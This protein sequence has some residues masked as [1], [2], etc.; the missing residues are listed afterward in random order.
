MSTF[1]GMQE[2]WLHHHNREEENPVWG[3]G[4]EWRP[5][6]WE[7]LGG[8]LCQDG[9]IWGRRPQ[10]KGLEGGTSQEGSNVLGTG[11]QF[12]NISLKVTLGWFTCVPACVSIWCLSLDF[13][14]A[15]A[16]DG[17][18]SW[19]YTEYLFKPTTNIWNEYFPNYLMSTRL[20]LSIPH[21]IR[22]H[23]PKVSS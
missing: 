8:Q 3:M 23:R 21:G 12:S 18:T 9:K 4:A 14:A 11:R 16:T 22:W 13:G 17:N 1:K 2:W 6:I 7:E 10:R 5:G 15:W 19:Y 20:Y